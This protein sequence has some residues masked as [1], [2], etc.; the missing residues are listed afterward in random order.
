MSFSPAPIIGWA[1]PWIA[2][3]LLGCSSSTGGSTQEIVDPIEKP[4]G[5]WELLRAK[6]D[7]NQDGFVTAEEY[8][9]QAA[10]LRNLDADGDGQLSAADFGEELLNILFSRSE[11]AQFSL[12]EFFQDDDQPYDLTRAECLRAF[13]LYDENQ[14]GQLGKLEFRARSGDRQHALLAPEWHDQP[15]WTRPRA[16]WGELRAGMDFDRDKYLSSAEV[17]R[18]FT[19]NANGRE[20]W[21]A[22]RYFAIP[23]KPGFESLSGPRLGELAPNFDLSPSSGGRSVSLSS[24]KDDRPVALIFGSFT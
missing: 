10:D 9:R 13:G 12:L 1:A 15:V 14:D 6:Y 22:E 3:F 2:V 18:F 19:Q 20:V 16:P 17:M 11:R 8:E 23:L 4:L 5:A 21:N 24:F 7:S